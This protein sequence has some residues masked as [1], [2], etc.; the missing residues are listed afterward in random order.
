MIMPFDFLDEEIEGEE[1]D[2]ALSEEREFQCDDCGTI[3]TT[4]ERSPT[5]L[6]EDF[7]PARRL[8][9]RCR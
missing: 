9:L 5:E 3:L 7:L 1:D 8:C 4:L 6:D 2:Q